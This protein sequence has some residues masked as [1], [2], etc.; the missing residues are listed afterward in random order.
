MANEINKMMLAELTKEFQGIR[1]CVFVNLSGMS[2]KE[3]DNL[4]AGFGEWSIKFS[5]VKNPIALR[6]LDA[7]GVKGVESYLVGPTAIA[8]GDTESAIKASKVL[9]ETMKTSKT[10]VVKGGF[11]EG[12]V[13]NA[14]QAKQLAK[15]PSKKELFSSILGGVVSL[16]SAPASLV[17]SAL[18]NP[19]YLGNAL[20]D[21]K[22]KAPAAGS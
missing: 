3:I 2:A 15:I 10:L 7:S 17:Q 11:L 22:E 9:T 8:Y 1:S 5:V 19:A 6:A 14:D 4:R 20:A 12:A 16:M 18:S 21:K 13:L